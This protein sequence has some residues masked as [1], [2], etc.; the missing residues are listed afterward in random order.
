MELFLKLV[1]GVGLWVPPFMLFLEVY[2]LFLPEVSTFG[3]DGISRFRSFELIWID[4]LSISIA[5][6]MSV[7]TL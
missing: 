6:L 7:S 3:E 1:Y 2:L 4:S 5:S